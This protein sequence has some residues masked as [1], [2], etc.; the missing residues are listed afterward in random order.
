MGLWLVQSLRRE[1]CP[2]KDFGTIAKESTSSTYDYLVDVN[3]AS[4]FAPKS[5][6]GALDAYL[7][8]KG[9]PLPTCEA[10]YFNCAYRSL[11]D[12]YRICI[13]ELCENSGRSYDTLYIVGGGAKNTYLNDLVEEI[14][15]VRVV[16]LP[17]EATALGNLK[18]QMK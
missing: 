15:G 16:A 10:D 14:A 13:A 6:K 11:A 9:Y 8:G 18:I 3:D 4:F 5:M 1:L 7:L 17:I 12:G 2:D